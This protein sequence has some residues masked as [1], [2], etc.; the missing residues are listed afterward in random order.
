MPLLHLPDVPMQERASFKQRILKKYQAYRANRTAGRTNLLQDQGERYE[1]AVALH[2]YR[3]HLV[4]KS[5]YLSRW[6]LTGEG[7]TQSIYMGLNNEYDFL[8]PDHHGLQ[9]GDAKSDSR[10]LGV[11]LKK[12]VSFCLLDYFV[13]GRESGI[14]GFCF[15]TPSEPAVMFR[16]GLRNSWE[17]LTGV[18][19][20]AGITGMNTQ[21]IPLAV[22]THFRYQYTAGGQVIRTDALPHGPEYY[23]SELRDNAGFT[24]RFLKVAPMNEPELERQMG[25]IA[26]NERWAMP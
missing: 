2:L 21:L 8:V 23:L 20:C 7:A 6:L 24:F 5:E 14:S 15:A 22:R 1:I 11:Y 16:T 19:D 13:R 3:N 12:A 9:L 26:R 10:G 18:S 25:L 4:N 17:V